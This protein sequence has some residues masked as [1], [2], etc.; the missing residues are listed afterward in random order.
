MEGVFMLIPVS[1]VIVFMVI[2]VFVWSVKNGQYEDLDKEAQRI[3]FDDDELDIDTTPTP[4]PK[5]KDN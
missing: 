4:N 2:T 3:L 1:L 5:T